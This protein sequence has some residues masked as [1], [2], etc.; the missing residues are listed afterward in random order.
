MMIALFVEQAEN[1]DI[2]GVHLFFSR[3]VPFV[4][5]ERPFIEAFRREYGEDPRRLPIDDRRV[6]KMRARFVLQL[7]RDLREALSRIGEQKGKRLQIAMHV[8]N[9]SDTCLFYGM[10]I[11]AMIRE[12]LVDI[13]M[14]AHSAFLP[15]EL[16]EK[17]G[18][19][20]FANESAK[21]AVTKQWLTPI[22][23]CS[24]ENVREFVQI[25]R[26]SGV[27]ICPILDTLY[28]NDGLT[29]TQ[30]AEAYYQAGADGLEVPM[31]EGLINFRSAYELRRR[32]G[33]VGQLDQAD[34]AARAA[35]RMVKV[36]TVAGLRIDMQ[37]G[38]P[39]CG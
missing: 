11:E 29:V 2:D 7:L 1:Y 16:G 5:F 39:T 19:P 25:A 6:W 38:I 37:Y 14:P 17:L 20:E 8:M 30:R 21:Q 15:A 13:L 27:R 3:G 12:Q 4:F 10:D 26:G 31:H 22:A 36:R 35:T 24:A 33:H 32:L 34:A 23:R 9:R 18:L 28:W